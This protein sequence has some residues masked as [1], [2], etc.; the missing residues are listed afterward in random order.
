[1]LGSVHLKK[2]KLAGSSENKIAKDKDGE[3]VPQLKVTEV[4][5]VHCTLVNNV[6]Q[7]DP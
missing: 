7:H 6:C 3:N 2:I 1:M 4:V 5:L